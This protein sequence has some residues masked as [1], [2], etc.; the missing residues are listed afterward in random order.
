[1]PRTIAIGDI[2]GAL[3][4]LQELLEVINPEK[5]DQFIFLGDY[6]DGWPDSAHVVNFLIG[7][8]KDHHCHFIR[9]NHDLWCEHWLHGNKADSTWLHHG[10]KATIESYKQIE[11]PARHDHLDFF[12]KLENYLVDESNRLFIHAG[13]SSLEGPEFEFRNGKY[14]WDRSL[15]QT[16]LKLQLKG[17]L[18]PNEYPP[19]FKLYTEIFIGHTPTI[20]YDI[21]VPI[22]ALNIRNIDTGAGFDGKLS[23]IEINTGKLWQSASIP[24][25]YPGV[26]GRTR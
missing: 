5:D 2:H 12:A 7:F 14:N 6:V 1:M 16:A 8:S 9:G 19:V 11:D 3:K 25:Y 4:A 21:T 15:W 26:K 22:R 18:N 17:G 20:F 10:G 13:Y 23:A 24:D